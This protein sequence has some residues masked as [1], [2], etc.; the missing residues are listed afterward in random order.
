MGLIRNIWQKEQ[1]REQSLM[2]DASFHTLQFDKW[3]TTGKK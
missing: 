1:G 3:V 2:R